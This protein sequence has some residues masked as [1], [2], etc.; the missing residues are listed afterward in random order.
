MTKVVASGG[1]YNVSFCQWLNRK[2]KINS[3]IQK[4]AN[5]S[6]VISS[7]SLNFETPGNGVQ[8]NKKYPAISLALISFGMPLAGEGSL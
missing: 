3:Q 5:C 2:I 4:T 6:N 8:T 7:D 1:N